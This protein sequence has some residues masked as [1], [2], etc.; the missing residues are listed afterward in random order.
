MCKLFIY[1]IIGYTGTP[2]WDDLMTKWLVTGMVYGIGH[3]DGIGFA[4]VPPLWLIK[5]MKST[6]L[7]TKMSI[8]SMAML[9]YQKLNPM[10]NE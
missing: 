5:L 7:T 6:V 10:F 3:W 2:R 9:N 1:I 4:T 8:C